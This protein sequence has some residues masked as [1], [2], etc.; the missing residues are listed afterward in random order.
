[1]ASTEVIRAA[2]RL[3]YTPDATEVV[4]P[5]PI[6]V[7]SI[8]RL[9]VQRSSRPEIEYEIFSMAAYEISPDNIEMSIQYAKKRALFL[10]PMYGR[11]SLLLCS[12]NQVNRADFIVPARG[13]EGVI[14]KRTSEIN[15]QDLDAEEEIPPSPFA[16]RWPVPE[17]RAISH[18]EACQLESLLSFE[19]IPAR[20][21]AA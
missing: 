11:V 13:E 7:D 8:A 9:I 6:V 12:N 10:E 5:H 16:G 19:Q 14:F 15:L 17:A 3:F 18:A 4:T 21:M 1:M 2:E 20:I